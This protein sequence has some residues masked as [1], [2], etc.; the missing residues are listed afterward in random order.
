M[1]FA[2]ARHQFCREIVPQFVTDNAI[3][4]AIRNTVEPI[5]GPPMRLDPVAVGREFR[6]SQGCIKHRLFPIDQ[7]ISNAGINLSPSLS[8]TLR[9]LKKQAA[10]LPLPGPSSKIVRE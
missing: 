4:A 8:R 10:R 6:M 9:W 2:C 7:H 3:H 5:H 1:S